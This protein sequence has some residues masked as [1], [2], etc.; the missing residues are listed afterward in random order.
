[1]KNL[2]IAVIG[3]LF[4]T[5]INAQAISYEYVDGSGNVYRL[6]PSLIDYE[7]VQAEFSSS[8]I[9]SGG[10]AVKKSLHP[11]E[12]EKISH[13]LHAAINNDAI[14]IKNRLM[15]SGMIVIRQQTNRTIILLA[16]NAKEKIHLEALLN[17]LIQSTQ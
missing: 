5:T 15:G 2:L 1:M 11:D 9:Y 10:K 7:P 4:C 12:Y 16:Q 8:G 6:S 17:E 13:I 14:H 3:L